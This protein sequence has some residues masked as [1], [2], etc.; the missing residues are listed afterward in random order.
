M[1]E[2]IC[3]KCGGGF[4]DD[5]YVVEI[6]GGY[7]HKTCAEINLNKDVCLKCGGNLEYGYLIKTE[8]GYLHRDCQNINT[9]NINTVPY[10]KSSAV[11]SSSAI[12]ILRVIAILNLIFGIIGALSIWLTMSTTGRFGVILGF[13]SLYEGVFGWALLVA[14]VN[15]ADNVIEI[16][17]IISR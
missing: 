9:D 16:R 15:I 6:E 17:R 12:K 10:Y 7:L 13:V 14:I 8:D 4:L 11:K 3:F 2:K 5:S 1:K